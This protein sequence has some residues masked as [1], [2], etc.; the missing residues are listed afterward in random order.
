M[1]P[2]CHG[3]FSRKPGE[4]PNVNIEDSVHFGVVAQ[5]GK[6][7]RLLELPFPQF[8]NLDR[9]K[10][11]SPNIAA[12]WELASALNT[13]AFGK[14][15]S[16]YN[17]PESRDG[18]FQK[19]GQTL[20]PQLRSG[21]YDLGF[22]DNHC[23]TDKAGCEPHSVASILKYYKGPL[24]H[25]NAE[26]YLYS[27]DLLSSDLFHFKEYQSPIYPPLARIA[28]IQGEVELE[29]HADSITGGVTDV[30]AISGHPVLQG[31][32]IEAARLWKFDLSY[33]TPQPVKAVIKFGFR[34]PE[35]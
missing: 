24:R 35:E 26:A 28:T 15:F 29:I 32:A 12:L 31:A 11:V 3:E 16:F 25:N 23:W 18:E 4:L 13:R 30:R 33:P 27:S 1:S 14:D 19:L 22:W 9:L 10:R 17:V 7:E 34:C 20:V 21:I 6:E 5:C 8:A 2:L